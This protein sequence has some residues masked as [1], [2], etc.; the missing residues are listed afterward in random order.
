MRTHVSSELL[1][2]DGTLF[3]LHFPEYYYAPDRGFFGDFEG[4]PRFCLPADPLVGGIN[5]QRPRFSLRFQRFAITKF[6][7]VLFVLQVCSD[8]PTTNC[9][10]DAI[11]QLL[12]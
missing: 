5:P 2:F 12:S 10:T 7:K 9:C 3:V 6:R 11:C 8:E 1:I 4:F